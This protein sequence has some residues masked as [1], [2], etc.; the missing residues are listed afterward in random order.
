MF[1]N[2]GGGL[3][4]GGLGGGGLGGGGDAIGGGGASSHTETSP[5]TSSVVKN[6]AGLVKPYACRSASMPVKVSLASGVYPANGGDN[7]PESG[8][9]PTQAA[10]CGYVEASTAAPSVTLAPLT[11]TSAPTDTAMVAPL[12]GVDSVSVTRSQDSTTHVQV[13]S[14]SGSGPVAT[15]TP[16]VPL[17]P[18]MADACPALLR[19]SATYASAAL[20]LL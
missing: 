6:A 18:M 15:A 20:P 5:A 2:G 9:P 7:K 11:A 17:A 19:R 16:L 4:G 10:P 8:A 1:N 12:A 3:G 13:P 14:T